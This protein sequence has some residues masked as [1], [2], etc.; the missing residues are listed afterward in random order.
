MQRTTTGYTRSPATRVARAEPASTRATNSL[1][2]ALQGAPLTGAEILHLQR[3]AG[4]TAVNRLIAQRAPAAGRQKRATPASPESFADLLQGIN[5]IA[6]AAARPH[7]A[8]V[9]DVPFGS[10]LTRS[11]HDLLADL[12]TAVVMAYAAAPGQH[13]A[14]LNLWTVIQP[15]LSSA[16]RVAPEYVEGDVGGIQRDLQW[17]DDQL[18]R[19][20][21]YREAHDEAV[22]HSSMKAPDLVFQQQRLEE[23]ETELEQAKGLA[24]DAAKLASEGASAAL[25]KD[26]DLGKEIFELVSSKGTIQEKLEKAKEMGIV[27]QTATAVEL[28]GKIAGLKNTIIATTM[29]Y[30]K[31]RAERFAEKAL[32]EGA[33]ELAKHW[34]DVADGYGETV[35]T[36]KTVGKVLGMVGVFADAIRTFKA[37]WDGDWD[38]VARNLASTEMGLL[39]TFAA[40]GSAPLLGG[41]T[42]TI[43]A[44]IEAI[45]LA[46]EFIRWCAQETVRVAASRFIDACSLVAKNVAYDFV[47]DVD[48]LLSSGNPEISRMAAQQITVHT[49]KMTQAL[50][51]LSAQ[52]SIS[53]AQW[54][55]LL[56]TLGGAAQ[57]ALSNPIDMP[58]DALTTAEQMRDIFAGANAMATY[59]KAHYPTDAEKAARQV[60]PAAKG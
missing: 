23:A 25:L 3:L 11:H 27:E 1:D 34:K 48:L 33:K 46:A 9:G 58:D 17:L 13:Q 24:E 18:I 30:L 12:R 19:P 39:G 37:A 26:A 15:D 4:N 32:E 20:A 41:I 52:A 16:V 40:E 14:A 57:H 49:A 5:Q 51:Y 42:I 31:G 50:H 43:K 10:H 22:A 54:P 38:A 53:E 45:H 35:Q 29:E 28:V 47:A 56:G 36:L 21:A 8:G 44:E 2:H 60:A 7:G 6:V 55:G 59:V